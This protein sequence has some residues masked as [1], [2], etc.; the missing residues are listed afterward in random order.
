[1]PRFL[2]PFSKPGR[3]GF[4]TRGLRDMWHRLLIFS[5]LFEKKVRKIQDSCDP[6]PDSPIQPKARGLLHMECDFSIAHHTKEVIR[7][8]STS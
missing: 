6:Q 4:K 7:G 5:N 2:D 1:M 8:M 3:F